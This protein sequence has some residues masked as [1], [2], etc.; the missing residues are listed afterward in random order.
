MLGTGGPARIRCRRGSRG[1][2]RRPTQGDRCVLQVGFIT[3]VVVPPRARGVLVRGVHL[4]RR[5]RAFSIGVAW[6]DPAINHTSTLHLDGLL[7]VSTKACP[8]VGERMSRW[9]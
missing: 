2:V 4:A 6:A 3:P 9:P 5:P 8:A 1:G 7:A